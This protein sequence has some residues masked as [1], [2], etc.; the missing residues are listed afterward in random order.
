MADSANRS[1]PT[2]TKP[3]ASPHRGIPP[4][5]VL[6]LMYRAL[7]LDI[8]ANDKLILATMAKCANP[9]GSSCFPAISTLMD[10][11]KLSESVI[12]SELRGLKSARYIQSVGKA[13][14][15]RGKT[16]EYRITLDAGDKGELE[17]FHAGEAERRTRNR[18]GAP[19]TPFSQTERVRLDASQ[20][21]KRVRLDAKKG[22]PGTPDLKS[23]TKSEEK[24]PLGGAISPSGEISPSAAS[25]LVPNLSSKGKL[26]QQQRW[27]HIE[28]LIRRAMELREDAPRIREGDLAEL[29]K[30]FAA[31]NDIPYFDGLRGAASPIDQAIMISEKRFREKRAAQ[32]EHKKPPA[33]AANKQ[34]HTERQKEAAAG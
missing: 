7:E 31:N 28:R 6:V 23:I 24:R 5:G 13:R 14:G 20:S 33:R 8:P 11:A 17:K 4:Q 1:T 27:S 12:H 22:A 15:G 21:I 19:G 16:S 18:K 10:G 2:K 34:A 25:P 3:D 26:P 29:L 32:G 30:Q 9:D